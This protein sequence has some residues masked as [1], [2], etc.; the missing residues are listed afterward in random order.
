[1][2]VNDEPG[3]SRGTGRGMSLRDL[4]AVVDRIAKG[5]K[6]LP[7]VHVLSSPAD[8]STIDPSQKA[9]R[10][11]IRKSDAWGDVEGATHDG[12]IYLFAS[13]MADEAR[14]EH[15]LATHE[16][17]HYGLRATMGKDLDAALQHVM[18]MNAKV[19][20]AAEAVKRARGLKSNIEAVEEVLADIPSA[21]LAKLR[22]W[23]KVVQVVRNWLNK[24]GAKNLAARLDGWMKTGLSEQEQADLFVADMVGAARQWVKS[25]KSVSSGIAGG[26]RLA[27]QRLSDDLAAQGKWLE[28]EAKMRGFKTIDD[29]A[30]KN[31]PLFEKLAALWR[32]KN[33]VEGALLSRKVGAGKTALRSTGFD[34]ASG[35]VVADFKNDNPLKAHADYK[36]AKAG[37]IDAAARLVQALVKPESIEAAKAFG[38]DA[39]YVP[40][41]AEEAS[42]RNQIPNML[43]HWYADQAGGEVGLGILQTNRAYHTGANAMKRLVSRAEFA[44]KVEPGRRYVIVDDVPTM[45]ST[46][47]D[48]ASYIRSQGGEVA[49]SVV[50]VNA[51]RG[52]MMTPASKTINELETRHGD[53]I[54]KLFGIEP[55]ALTAN[56]AQYLLG[57]RTTD[58][59]RNRVAKARSERGARLLAKGVSGSEDSSGGVTRL[60]RAA[61]QPV[62][63]QPQAGTSV[64]PSLKKRWI[65]LA[66]NV[67]GRMDASINGLGGLPDQARYLADRYLVMGKI[68]KIDEIAGSIR[69]PS[70]PTCSTAPRNRAGITPRRNWSLRSI[71]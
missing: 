15:V 35:T 57:F 49:G 27:E 70:I 34:K 22:G 59:L 41:H 53:E 61:K 30:E 25:G 29:L 42:G 9:L 48:L 37:D 18:L 64:P 5:F 55:G 66:D 31:Y 60:S 33:P 4:Q 68:G 12:E 38:E 1:M 36:A 14:A 71:G 16:I 7:R 10:D 51:M 2:A 39:I 40:V 19:R 52:G 13:G 45:G 8:L 58:E 26:T 44:G 28:R 24:A 54:R 17:T 50:L 23:R 63:S 6:N 69:K 67:I 21:D 20:K 65:A 46:L 47:A 62:S 43:A 3:L 32:K 56:E 11:F